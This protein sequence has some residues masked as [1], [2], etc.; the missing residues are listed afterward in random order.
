MSCRLRKLS[1]LFGV[2]RRQG[3]VRNA[4]SLT[5]A[6]VVAQGTGLVTMAVMTRLYPQENIGIFSAFLSYVSILG[7]IALLSYQFSIP[8]IND[9]DLRALL[10]TLLGLAGFSALLIW[11]VFW[12][13][14]YPFAFALSLR[15]GA[16]SLIL[17]AEQVNIR[18][19]RFRPIMWARVAPFILFFA[20][21]LMLIVDSANARSLVLAQTIAF[22][23]VALIYASL[24]LAPRFLGAPSGPRVGWRQIIQI[25]HANQKFTLYV[26]PSQLFNMAAYNLPTILIERFLGA[27]LAAQYAITLRFCFGPVNMIG[28]AIGETYQGK[29]AA[30]V[31][32]GTAGGYK[33][34]Q[35]LVKALTAVGIGIGAVIFL[36]FP[37]IFRLVFGPGWE[38]AGKMAQ[39]TAP[40]WSIMLIVSPL[41]VSFMV[42]K[43]QEYLFN[44]QLAYLMISIIS[45]G[46]AVVKT[47]ILIGMSLFTGLSLV[48]YGFI[49]MKIHRL[50]QQ[51][52]EGTQS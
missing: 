7:V 52:L 21:V 28:T 42:F 6:S 41:G 10:W 30:M 26:A 35:H 46:Y 38:L 34:Y 48:R 37:I 36:L 1:E 44:N 50:S 23:V 40:L 14:G 47:D 33:Q 4:A 9:N 12:L 51:N 18:Q 5:M 15:V 27:A 20:L 13:L 8:N 19:Q 11:L 24:T 32:S 2:I 39:I 45:F 22:G 25:L 3:F 17:I 31:R 29:L 16:G 49:F 43:Q